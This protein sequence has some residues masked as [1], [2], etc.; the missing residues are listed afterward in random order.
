MLESAKK[1]V[2]V[3]AAGRGNAYL[4]LKDGHQMSLSYRG[5]A[6]VISALR[7]STAG[8]RALAA[9]DLDGDGA[10]DLVVGYA[11]GGTGIVTVQRGNPEAF[12]PKDDSIFE[13]MHQ[14]YSPPSL[15]PTVDTYQSSAPVDFLQVG[16]F[17]G[18]NRRDVLVASRDGNLRLLPGDGQGGFGP[19]QV[20]SLPGTVT[21]LTAGEFRAADGK[22]DVAVGITG[23]EGPEVLVFDG[24]AGGFDSAPLHFP[25]TSR[26]V[27]VEFGELDSDPFMDLAIANGS[28][29]DVVHGWGRKV[30]ADQH[31]Q[32]ERIP[33]AY[34]AQSL[35][36]DNFTWDRHGARE[37]ALLADDGSVRMLENS[38]AD[39]RP[40][41]A[42]DIRARAAS[43]GKER[44]ANGPDVE[45]VRGWSNGVAGSWSEVSDVP[46]NAR[47]AASAVGQG[48]LTHAKVSS[49]ETNAL[50]VVNG[51]QKNLDLIHQVSS[52]EVNAK[53]SML[54]TASV[55]TVSTSS[56]DVSGTP[57]AMMT[58]PKKLD[59][60]RDMVVLT[61]ESSSAVF[62][63]ITPS[64]IFTI[65]TTSDHAPDG[66]CNTSPDC[67]LREAVIAADAVAGPTTINVPAGTFTLTI[68]GNTN[69]SGA[70]EG[71]SGNPA[72]G[73]LD[74]TQDGITVS[75]AGSGSTFIVQSTANDRVLE[76]NPTAQLNFDWAISGITI[77]GGRDTGG[78]NTGGG[79]A[80]LSGSK[81]NTTTVT[82]CV[83]ANNRATGTGTTGGGGILNEGGSVTVTNTVFGGATT[84]AACPSQTATNCGNASSA[85]GGGIGYSPGDPAGRT[86]SAGT[87]VI[88]TT[89]S[90]QNNTANALTAGGGGLDLFTHNLG[91][92]SVTISGTTFTSNAATG[93][94]SGGGIIVESIGTTIST[95]SFTNNS[96]G[97][98]GGGIQVAGGS[99][100]LDGTSPSITFTGNTA[101]TSGSSISTSSAVNLAG[102]NTTIGGDLEITTNGVWTNNTGSTMS[103]NNLII[104][105]T[106]S[107]TANNSTTNVSGN[108]QFQSGTFNA[109]TGLFN[110]NGSG[111]QT[112]NNSAAI[113]FNNLTDSNTTQPL[114]INNNIAVN[115][116]LNVNGANAALAPLAA[117]VIS[118]TGTLTGSGFA[119]VTRTAATADFS[120]Q[121]TITN[122]T[123]TNLTVDYVGAAAQVLSAIT[124]GGL[125]INNASGVTAAAGTATVNNTLTLTAGALNVS[126][127][128]LVINNGTSVAAGSITSAATGT[129]NYNQGS[130][131]QNVLAFNYGNLTFSNQN[132]VLASSGTIGV[133]GVFTPG[134]AVG[135]TI[136]GS[137]IDFNG[138]GAETIPAFNYNNLTSSSSGGRTLANAGT[139]GVAGNFTPGTNVFTITGSTIDYN[140]SGGQTISAFNYN[141]LTSS[142]SGARTLASSGTIGV[143]SV[144][145]PGTNTYTITGST[146][147]FNGGGAQSI[148]AF[149][150]FN[151]ISSST[152]ARTLPNGATVGVAGGFN[153]GTNA[154]T[155]T[156]STIDF[157]GAN[158]Q[159]ITAFNYN[160]LTSSN[161]GARTLANAGTIGVASVFTPGSN[162]YTITGSTVDF[163]GSGSQTI[164]AFNFNNLTSSSTGARTLAGSGSIGIAGV[165]TPGTNAYTITNSTV[166]FNGTSPQTLPS[167]FTTYNNLTLNN[168][169]GVTGFAGLTVQGLI[170][171]QAGTFTS[172]STYNNVQI[173]SGATLA[174]VSATTINVSG[175]WTN[176]GTFTANSNTV[177]FNGSGAQVIGG[178]AA[179]T[180]NNLTIANAGSGVSL[181]Q[182]ANV[183]GVLTLT[184]DLSTAANVLTMPNTGTST[185]TGDVIGNVKRTGFTG[186]GS[187]LSFGNPFNSI[188]FAAAGSVPTDVTVN[189]VKAAPISGVALPVAVQR[190]YTITPTGGS[191]FS[192]TLRL[193][194]LDP[195]LN[196]ND[197]TTMGLWRLG[198]A[199]WSRQ[200]KTA[201]DTSNNWVELS[202]VTQFSPWTLSADKNNTTTTITQDTPDPSTPNVPFDVFFTVTP[203]VAGGATPTGTVNVT[204]S[205][206]SETCSGT[207]AAGKCT[208]TLTSAGANRTIT[209]T[210]VGDA[211]SNGS[212]DTESHTACGNTL[213]TSTADTGAGSLRQ[214]IAD[215][216][217]GAKITFD[218]AGAFATPQTITLTS[219]EIVV[220]KNLTI[221]GPAAS[222]NK[223]TIS[224]N[225][226]SR[227]FNIGSG[228]TVS[229]IGLTLTG[230]AGAAD[231]G[232]IT[233]NGTLNVVN[234]TLTGNTSF[235]DGGAL[236]NSVTATSMTLINTTISGNNAN[237]NGGGV[238]VLG[239][240]MT[241][242]NSTITNNF[243]D[244]DNNSTGTGGG[245]SGNATTTLKNTIVAGNFNEDGATDAADDISGTIDAAS[246][247]NL[248]GTGGAGGLTNAVNSNQVGVASPGLGPLAD[249]GGATQT[250]ALLSNSPAIEAGSNAN[251]PADT[252]DL[253]GDA[254]TAETLPVD[255]RGINFPR[256]A[257]SADV[258]TTQTV[259][260]GAF[261]LHPSIE[262]IPNQTTS[263]S[264]VKNVSFN[265]G[266]D[267]GTLITGPG[268]SVTAT[269]SNTTLVPNANLLITG[270]G[271]SRNLQITPVAN[272]N[273]STTITV[274]V[275][276]TNGRTAT[277]T[278]DLTVSSV[279][280]PPSG[281]D[282]TVSTAE[283][284]AY[285]F[286]VVDFGFTDP[287]DTPANNLLAVKITTL[288]GLGT[289]TNNNVAVNAGDFIPVANITGGL[290]KFTPVA[291]ANGSPYTSFT[292]QVQD[293]GGGS[294]IDPT[295]NTMTI[296]VTAVN[297]APVNT[298]PGP[299]NT[300]QDTAKVFSSGNANQISVSDVDLGGNSI[301]I[302]LT[303]SNGT[304]TLS[305]IAGLSFT[306]GDGTDD[307][308][309]VFTGTLSAVNT[310]LNGMSFNPTPA[311]SGAASLQIISD[312][313]G[314]TGAGG[315]L[316]DTDSVNITVTAPSATPV[317][318]ATAGN[319]A[320]TENAGAVVIDSGLTVT[321]SD[322]PNLTGASV[323]ITAGFVSAEDT[324]AFT[325]QLGITGSYN[326]GTGVLTLSGTTTV[327]NYQ[328]A[329]RS[330]TYANGSDNPT[331]SRTITFSASD[332]TSSGTATRGI[333]ITAVNDAPVNTVPGPQT[334]NEDT[335]KVF[336]S[337]NGNQISV[338]D[339][340]LGANAIKITLTST[341]GKLTLSTIAG[342]SFITGDGT[343]DATMVF[344]GSLSAV[345]TALNGLSFNPNADFNGAASLQIISDDQGNTGTGGPLTDTDSVNITVTAVNDVPV[346]T[347]T[348]GNLSYTENAAATAIDPGLTVTDV[349]NANL[350][351]ATVAITANFVSAEDTLAFTNQLGITGNY[352]SATGVL[353]L[354]GT[355]TVA[356][357]QTALRSVTYH[358]SSENPSTALRTVTFSANDGTGSG[359]NTRGIDVI[360][361]ND[362]PVNTVPAAQTTAQ[363]TAKVFSSINSNQISVADV[364]L[365]ANSIKV[366]L[367]ASNGTI[368]LS[369]TAGLAFTVGDGTAD[370]TMTFT[371]LLSNVNTA[372]N[373]MS[374]TPTSG[375]N[376]AASLQITSDDQGNT[377]TGGALID[378]D[379][380]NITVTAPNAAPV[381]TTTAG[382]LSYTENAAAT[383]IDPALTVTDSDNANLVGATVAI[384]AN[385][386][387]GEDVLAFTNQL[388]I[389]GSYNSGTGVLTLTG[390]TTVANYQTALRSVTYQNSSDNPSTA[391]R[392]VRFTAD[393][394]ITPGSATRGIAVTAVNDA[395]V[396][397]V[398][399]PQNT[400]QNTPLTFNSGSG[401]QVAVSD[402]DAGTNAVRVTLTVTNGTLTLN[403][404]AGLAFTVGDGTADATMTF[405][406]T[407]ANINNALNGMTFT[408]TAGFS[409]TGSLTITTNDQG[410][411]GTGGPLSD[412]DTVNIQIGVTNVSISD[413]Q[414]TEPSSGSANMVF[415]V[416][417][418][419]PASVAG[420]TVNFTTQQQAPALNHATAGQDY[421]TTSGTLT[422][423]PGQQI[424]TIS[425]PILADNKKAEA[426]ETFL[427]VLSNPVNVTIT[428]GTATGT[429][430]I[431]NQ[432]GVIL[433]T[434]LRTS[435]PAG[436]GDDFVEVY[437]NS[438][439]PHTVNDGTGINDAAHG[440]GLYKMGADC[441]ANPVLIGI[442]PNGTVIPARG[443]YLFVGSAYS[444]ANYGGS[445]AAAGDQVLNQDIEDDRNVAL[446]KTTS[447]VNLST[448]TRL[449]AV[450]FGANTGA[451]CDLLREGTTLTPLSGSVLE[452]SYFRDECG[453]KGNPGS[454]GTCPTNG[455]VMDTSDNGDD[456]IFGDTLGTM[457]PAGQRLAAP[458]PQ[459]MSGP[460]LNLNVAALLL[461]N[462]KGSTADPNRVRDL[463]PAGP[464]AT[465]GTLSVRRRFVNS[466]GAP[467]TRLRFRIVDFSAFPVS[468]ATA[469]L[470]ALNSGTITVS[471]IKD[472]A[473]CAATGTPSSQPCTVTVF[474]TAI[475]T[476]PTQPLGGALN[477]SYNAGTISLPTPL[478]PGQSVNLQFLLGVQ[479]TGSFK[480][481]FNVEALP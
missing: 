409:G 127:N 99:L 54:S 84:V 357:Y 89:S 341:N 467:V 42:A 481:F 418:S 102:T 325:N 37:I 324:L 91:T 118:G 201:N 171:V 478:A 376:G 36:V 39:K 40:M 11:N 7:N 262:D 179:T 210:Y 291:D 460:R 131:G 309:M 106:G 253:D 258:N 219:G 204:I 310:A 129:V 384:T 218:T 323:A 4:N 458:G 282:N 332:G 124:Y 294:D 426:N 104:I 268:G 405:T 317:V 197:E 440:Y 27:A 73:D 392:T 413:S 261:E 209:A 63:P 157:N 141:N 191:G 469:D 224:G 166:I 162:T 213:V 76:P 14:G 416:T 348:A 354:T 1:Q 143:A 364:D 117:T 70:G 367:T 58:L 163:N 71:F 13:R 445:G 184:N 133:A 32:M 74:F 176:N 287:N 207:V 400:A 194:Y 466:T 269:S 9:A 333:T 315:A 56:L 181:G 307:A 403:G 251:V 316:T 407:I 196:A 335:A 423:G 24:G 359:N 49:G 339:V 64:A 195:E 472:S 50:M 223:V 142:N 429:I 366:T 355:T 397:I 200:G 238:A 150:Y 255:Q 421:T 105:G 290:L 452:Y 227:V 394:G 302:T 336:S 361:V 289:L 279:N 369:T 410:N 353:T 326:S 34:G 474:G 263:E 292:F 447:I 419:A 161:S 190:L 345:N 92:G 214:I 398:P 264:T 16:D 477:S 65:N 298:V 377:G 135:H 57:V 199:G 236:S 211:N 140:G 173:D 95:T 26:A 351:G 6:G 365:G 229:V 167:G 35:A 437:N 479:K 119:R 235:T 83:I 192:A 267:T 286:A 10:P 240:S 300:N 415:T 41:T 107:F 443:H 72:I 306:T 439:S 98:R 328:T 277:D 180:F 311:F 80:M 185:G 382:N 260:I 148:P 455:F 205:G 470:R 206:G 144:F 432:P 334:T 375:F 152:G 88:Q 125:R 126:T 215:A 252:F 318:T 237:G 189:L 130:A 245:I 128:T 284:T 59:G 296:N 153:P 113:T 275:T 243:A 21:S 412:T 449:D 103:P 38:R 187:A 406:G 228:N 145:T 436:S 77:A 202:G 20:I 314:F 319:L 69:S 401:N 346:V 68:I 331:A 86:P 230:G 246:S 97:N 273:G 5:N 8:S 303:G 51:E 295:P 468:G 234:S 390:T 259:D 47:A 31:Q 480:F 121:Y 337:G 249:N 254:N 108:F 342:L 33:L 288:P 399:G 330:V 232:A 424:K 15:L 151:L 147:N 247:F 350:T 116:T 372:L 435:G 360:A 19:E 459:N 371:G 12:A 462:T 278:F 438:D 177:N 139:I 414:L 430:L 321:D 448:Q 61:E 422:F 2:T 322:S 475:E 344:T 244:N 217:D 402:V 385:F 233:N 256:V 425:V 266:D 248:I 188:G 90:F 137:T 301:K 165:F 208:L 212:S 270:S 408:P 313:Q 100:L 434:E 154:F 329:L 46:L 94:A 388:G 304:I 239:G 44:T 62:V 110:F 389:S 395:P 225:N 320:Y 120:S 81:D 293:D 149:N 203:N 393:D 178:S 450:G 183:N 471:G 327:A 156:G 101:T 216:C 87:M 427:V 378:T 220:S 340:D 373:G 175:N 352:N 174:G 241:I 362:A 28:E 272:G 3:Q 25:V 338:A 146:I 299:Q 379:T 271:G 138:T 281:A 411:S 18:D 115:G 312:D 308:T 433:I 280:N 347:T 155:I 186:G 52:K 123:L 60:S 451:A 387:S 45:T 461:D 66:A 356:N 168:T 43:R 283:D 136:T 250:H 396:N 464:L 111:S 17:N 198:G 465:Q 48:L 85:S 274:T 428:N 476:P 221:T 182:N 109:G 391:I 442:I 22:L 96:A 164:P 257:D 158:P 67:T 305:T 29:V 420:A 159:T 112:I 134:T 285:T 454:F 75:G 82:N 417:L 169:A 23:P 172:S 53:G 193:H 446:F 431:T 463:T 231:G 265:I 444:L 55:G 370:P 381:V 276:A 457:T 349:D 453:K 93:T 363:D 386:A 374:F 160:N 343:D 170:R 456:F 132:K 297:D 441:N 242:I 30:A 226:A 368:T 473:T 380:V 358:N 222:A 383:A 122:K 114:T 79:G 404:T 78:S